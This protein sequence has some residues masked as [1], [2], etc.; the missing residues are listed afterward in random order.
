M[1]LSREHTEISVTVKKK[2]VKTEIFLSRNEVEQ[3]I[4]AWLQTRPNIDLANAIKIDVDPNITG[5]GDWTYEGHIV[6]SYVEE[7]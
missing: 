7:P 5:Y 1:E 6:T 2:V 4:S 3:A